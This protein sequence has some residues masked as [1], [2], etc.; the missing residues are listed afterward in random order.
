MARWAADR[1]TPNGGVTVRYHTG[2][3][4]EAGRVHHRNEQALAGSPIDGRNDPVQDAACK[5][6]RGNKAP[7]KK[8]FGNCQKMVPRYTL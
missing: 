4:F 6:G 7:T 2:A 1:E 3:A 8:C 5:G